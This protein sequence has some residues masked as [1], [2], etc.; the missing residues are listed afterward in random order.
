MNDIFET[1]S[2]IKKDKKISISNDDDDEDILKMILEKEKPKKE[3]KKT[4][5]EMTEEQRILMV[6]RLKGMRETLAKKREEKKK[7]KIDTKTDTK[8]DTKEQI[9]VN[10]NNSTPEPKTQQKVS[11]SKE[12][13][14]K[15]DAIN[16]TLNKLLSYKEEKIKRK[17][18]QQEQPKT[19]EPKTTPQQEQPKQEQPKPQQQEIQHI[20]DIE[21]KPLPSFRNM[22][23]NRFYK[24]F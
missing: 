4:K 23:N 6:E 24:R 11:K 5:R 20:P 7:G 22:N 14:E 18:Q 9:Q 1:Q 3:K 12:K 17:T 19:E 8:T 16:N 21:D 15:L 10:K 2:I 13:I